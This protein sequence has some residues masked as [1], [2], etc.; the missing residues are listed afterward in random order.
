MANAKNF[1]SSA[2]AME[3]EF[4][5]LGP[6]GTHAFGWIAQDL[7]ADGG[8]GDASKGRAEK[9]EK[10]AVHQIDGFVALLRDMTAFSLDRL[11]TPNAN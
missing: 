8:V 5:H 9:G 1:V 6:T 4:K 10:T 7:N 2:I 3:K 11:Y